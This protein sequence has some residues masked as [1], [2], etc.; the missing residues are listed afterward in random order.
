MTHRSTRVGATGGKIPADQAGYTTEVLSDALDLPVK[1]FEIQNF[2]AEGSGGGF[3]GGVVCRVKDIVYKEAHEENL[4]TSVILKWFNMSNSV[5]NGGAPNTNFLERVLLFGV[6]KLK[7]D[8]EEVQ[9]REYD[10]FGPKSYLRPSIENAGIKIPQCYACDMLDFGTPTLCCKI[11]CNRKTK[12]RR[13]MVFEDITDSMAEKYDVDSI[14]FDEKHM[15]RAVENMAKIHFAN[16]GYSKDPKVAVRVKEAYWYACVFGWTNPLRKAKR[17]YKFSKYANEWR[18]EREYLNEHRVSEALTRLESFYRDEISNIVEN[19]DHKQTILHGDYHFANIMFLKNCEDVVMLDWQMYGHG[20]SLYEFCY[21]VYFVL[22]N[23]EYVDRSRTFKYLKMYYDKLSEL[24]VSVKDQISWKETQKIFVCICLEMYVW[25]VAC[26]RA[27][28]KKRK[29]RD[30]ENV[31]DRRMVDVN[32]VL[33]IRDKHL[34]LFVVD[35]MN[36]LED[37]GW[38]STF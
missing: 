17:R 16:W 33:D 31:K 2:G 38:T 20:Y 3:A 1:S 5:S 26:Y 37:Y 15:S 6:C 7:M 22:A 14:K 27:D 36:N 28:I 18:I 4:P 30:K 19:L 8:T 9:R 11:L 12:M 35:L 32:K 21:F 29:M 23:D 34:T 25:V 13:Y 10:F 24:M